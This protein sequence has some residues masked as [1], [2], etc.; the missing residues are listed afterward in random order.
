MS[1]TL[2]AIHRYIEKNI[3]EEN[4]QHDDDP[5]FFSIVRKNNFKPFYISY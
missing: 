4:N 2:V 5:G 1:C 3:W